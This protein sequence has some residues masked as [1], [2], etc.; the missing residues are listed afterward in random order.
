VIR[1]LTIL[2]LTCSC[3]WSRAQVNIITTIAGKDTYGYSGDG[4]PATDAQ[5]K[6][7]YL[8]SKNDTQLCV[9][10]ALNHCIR[11]VNQITHIISTIAGTG[12]PGYGGDNGMATDAKLQVPDGLCLDN[13]G[14]IYITDAGNN[15]IRKVNVATGKIVT[16]GGNGVAGDAGDGGPATDAEF[17]IPVGLHVD[18]SGNVYIADWGNNRVRKIASATGIISTVIGTGV[19]GYSGDGGLAINAEINRPVQLRSDTSGNF[20]LTEQ[21]SHVVRKIDIATGI[22]NTIAGTGSAG[23]SGDGGPATNARLNQPAGVFVDR[24]NNIYVAEY[25]NGTIRRIDGATG[26]ITTVAGTGTTGFSGDG[27]PATDAKLF[28]TDV[29]VD[30]DG[31]LI[32]ADYEN[33]RI[34]KVSSSVAVNGIDKEVEGKLYPNPTNGI[35]SVQTPAAISL[36][37]VYNIGGVLVHEQTCIGT[38]TQVDITAQPPGAYIVYVRCGDKMYVSKVV[39]N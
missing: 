12:T 20:L 31:N 10:D 38:E 9:C 21:N 16:I 36:V 28:C 13:V 5:L 24:Q 25:G 26:I 6:G 4:G 22:I 39:K 33:N 3:Q 15:R 29:L 37:S 18:N 19:G 34:R 35:F 32:I 2:I 27:G 1:L 30:D 11:K 17:Y 14:N 7:P 23:Y 8:I